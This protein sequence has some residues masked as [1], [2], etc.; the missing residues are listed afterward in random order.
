[1]RFY[2]LLSLLLLPYF[3]LAQSNIEL[4]IFAPR[5][6]IDT[7]LQLILVQTDLETL[8]GNIITPSPI[9][10]IL[11]QTYQITETINQFETTRSYQLSANDKVWTLY[12]TNAP[13]IHVQYEADTIPNEPKILA[14]F[15]FVHTEI[16]KSPLGIELRGGSSISFPKRSY[17]IELWVD[18]SGDEKRKESLHGMRKDDDWALLGMYNE[19]LRLRNHMTHQLW[20]NIHQPHYISEKPTAESGADFKYVELFLNGQYRGLYLLGELIDR[21]QLQLD[22]FDGT[23]RGELYK[24]FFWHNVLAFN[25]LTNFNPNSKGWGGFEV[26]Y[27]DHKDTIHWDLLHELVDF[28]VNENDDIFYNNIENI[29]A[30]ENFADFYLLLS[31]MRGW[32]NSSKNT[33]LAKHQQ[34]GKYFYIP[35][36]FDGVWGKMYTGE[37]DPSTNGFPS[38]GL[39]NRLLMANDCNPYIDLI[40]DRWT[41]LKSSHFNVAIMQN[42]IDSIYYSLLDNKYYERENLIWAGVLNSDLSEVAFLKDWIADRFQKVDQH[43]NQLISPDTANCDFVSSDQNQLLNSSITVFP[44]PSNGSV[45][46]SSNDVQPIFYKIF[47]LQ[48]QRLSQGRIDNETV[49]LDLPKGMAILFFQN[50]EGVVDGYWKVLVE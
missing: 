47:N 46:I 45:F 37:P 28:V 33:Y 50:K 4:T 41:V 27:P 35:W 7:S 34:G 11:D 8:N 21:K 20:Q 26:K 6:Q 15:T 10:L 16:I 29:I 36:D 5:Y 40:K 44:N 12:F 24:G 19:A 32:D 38:N 48:G 14:E 17:N 13:I 2:Y 22:H 1:M 31:M 18:E 39:L 23:M 9:T 3:C 43:I 49:S 25:G 42:R 30:L